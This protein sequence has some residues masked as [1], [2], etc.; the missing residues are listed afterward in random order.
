MY[1]R[2]L[3]CYF[4]T[5]IIVCFDQTHSVT[6]YFPTPIIIFFGTGAWTQGFHLESLHQHYFCEGFFEIGSHE[7]ICSG[8]LQT[9]IL[10]IS[11]SWVARIT[12]ASHWCQAPIFWTVLG[13]EFR[14]LHLPGKQV[15]YHF[16]HFTSPL[17]WLF[18]RDR[19]SWIIYPG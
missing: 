17:C 2:L 1:K 19:V 16:S 11:A 8:L 5:C 9:A 10:L 15:L 7:T 12:E 13:L 18:F 4:H 3:L 6:L 14:A